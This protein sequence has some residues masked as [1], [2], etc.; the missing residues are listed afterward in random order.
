MELYRSISDDIMEILRG[1]CDIVEQESIDEAFCDITGNVAD[2]DESKKLAAQIKDVIMK[3]VGLTCSIGVAS[4]KLVAKIASDFKKPDGLTI[5]KPEEVRQFLDPLKVTDLIGVGKKTGERLNELGINTIGDLSKV[6]MKALVTEFGHARGEWLIQASQGLD[7]SPVQ[8]REG[9]EQ[10]GR[11]ITLKEDTNDLKVILDAVDRLSVDVFKKL[12]ERKL[13]FRSVTFIGIF[14][15]FKTHTKSRTL[16][17]PARDTGT[18]SSMAKDLAK[19][20]HAAHP[21][22]LRRVGIRVANFTGEKAQM[23]LGEF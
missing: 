11:I 10:I 12:E 18:I 17:A 1:F 9:T 4:N 19:D 6:S 3:N 15:D 14:T 5:V 21:G 2:F 7:L 20:F 23:T 22:A 8:E 16:G 13:S